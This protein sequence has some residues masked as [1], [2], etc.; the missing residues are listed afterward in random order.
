MTGY[1]KRICKGWHKTAADLLK[2]QKMLEFTLKRVLMHEVEV[3]ETLET[4]EVVNMPI[5]DLLVIKK[6]G[7]DLE[8]PDKIDLKTYSA[9]LGELKQEVVQN[10]EAPSEFFRGVAAGAK[11]DGSSIRRTQDTDSR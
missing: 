4:G 8:H 2:D 5:I 9:V 7:F 3:P 11:P 1:E 10:I 6:L